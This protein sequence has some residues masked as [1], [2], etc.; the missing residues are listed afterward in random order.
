MTKALLTWAAAIAAAVAAFGMPVQ[1][2]HDLFQQALVKERAEGNLQ[3]AI[4]LY[5]RI[6]RDFPDDHALAAKALV[7]M[8]QC[9]EKLGRAEAKKAYERVI[10]DYADQAEP[11]Q[12]ARA[13]LA[14]LTRPPRHEMTVR[15]VWSGPMAD[16]DGEISPDGRYL[17][18]VDWDD[19]RPGRPGPHDGKNRRLTNK[20]P[21]TDSQELRPLFQVVSRRHRRSPTTGMP[22]PTTGC[23]ELRVADIENAQSRLLYDPG[24]DVVYDPWSTG[25]RTAGRSVLRLS[26]PTSK[27]PLQLAAIPAAGGKVRIIKGMDGRYPPDTLA[28]FSPDGRQILCTQPSGK[29][30]G[31]ADV[32]ALSSDGLSETRLVD[33][34]ANDVAA[35]WSPDG[36]WVLFVSDRTGTLDLWMIPVDDGKPSGEPRLVKSGTGRIWP[37][38]FDSGGR[39]YYGTGSRGGDIYT[40]TLDPL[41][42]RVLSAPSRA[43]K[44]FQGS[45]EWPSYSKEG[46]FLA[47]VS[48]AWFFDGPACSFQRP[49]HP[50]ARDRRGAGVCD[51]LS[52]AG[53]PPV[54]ARRDDGVRGGMGRREQDR[55]L[56]GGHDQPGISLLSWR[57][58][59]V[60]ASDAHAVAPDGTALFYARCDDADKACRIV[61]RDLASGSDTEMYRGPDERPSIALSPD[62]RTLAF[63]TVP[64][65]PDSERV[66][67]VVPAA[68]G[69]PREIYRF[70][71]FGAGWIT[72]EFSAD[73]KSLFIPRKLTPP[74]DPYW[75]LFSVPVEGGEAQDLGV[76]MVSI[77][78]VTA[79]PDG[80]RVSFA[81]RGAEEKGDEVWVIEDFLPKATARP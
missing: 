37:L 25:L 5:D 16:I 33:H 4:D 61:K 58:E 46:A 29:D 68:G 26:A 11:L 53:R 67:R 55:H 40:L 21:W 8:G 30:S 44:R 48:A 47:Y 12:V 6:V 52:T 72:L 13:R 79:H 66:V 76:K 43:I 60:R 78:K 74:E 15:R 64:R 17:S 31:S 18:F 65:E 7:Q 38:G 77:D 32:F 9:Y 62:G 28:G 56:P 80:E 81:S 14:A 75:T 70:R 39:Y 73:G 27:K 41:T 51:G 42:G 34:P 63:I 59:R 45:N 19:R 36:K 54:L 50:L 22:E 1:S 3:E 71:H 20:G 57:R 35:G 23:N 2:G 24:E 49:L 10:R 69:A